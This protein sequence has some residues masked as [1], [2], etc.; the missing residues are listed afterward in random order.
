M[1]TIISTFRLNEKPL[2]LFPK[3]LARGWFLTLMAFSFLIPIHLCQAQIYVDPCAPVEGDGSQANPFKTLVSAVDKAKTTPGSDN[4]VMK[5]GEYLETLTID[6]AVTLTA[7]GGS[8]FVGRAG[9]L[10]WRNMSINVGNGL[11]TNARAYYPSN[12]NGENAAISCGTTFPVIVY[13]HGK[14][15][16]G[17]SVL[18]SW[19]DNELRTDNTR[20]YLQ[21]EGMIKRLAS[22]GA[23]VVSFDWHTLTIHEN[24]IG[25]YALDVLNHMGNE[26]GS[27][28]DLNNVGLIG[29]S[30][31]GAAVMYTAQS[32]YRNGNPSKGIALIAPAFPLHPNLLGMG[33]ET[34]LIN[35]YGP[36]L[37]VHGTNE[38]C[39]QVGTS[40]LK[41]YCQ[42]TTPKHLVVITGANHFGY[43]EGICLDPD[44]AREGQCFYF[45]PWEFL[46]D[47]DGFD[48]PSEV[49]GLIGQKAQSLQQYS[50]GN[51]LEVFFS[52]YLHSNTNS[53]EYLNQRQKN[54]CGSSDQG[55][56]C[57]TFKSDV[58]M[59]WPN[60]SSRNLCSQTE[61]F[62][63]D[64][65]GNS[66]IVINQQT[67]G[68]QWNYLGQF[69]FKIGAYVEI[70]SFGS[71]SV[72]ADAVKFVLPDTAEEFIIDNNSQYGALIKQG[73]WNVSLGGSGWYSEDYLMSTDSNAKFRF[74]IT[75][76][77]IFDSAGC[78]PI[79]YFDDLQSLGVE[80]NVCSCL[81]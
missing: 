7:Q 14:R 60:S 19:C 76:P 47:A 35:L 50:L 68:D 59:W 57:S 65:F 79:K 4:I 69:E 2:L 49:G 52:Y 67:N 38:H 61:I 58:Y 17:Q 66:Q 10:G 70:Q 45:N 23:I 37:V 64:G 11:T 48:N 41:I 8:A 1:I 71:C 21:A 12:G 31:G 9:G 54:N 25:S 46:T 33:D 20:D 51:Y 42:T 16:P 77:T 28:I 39:C 30:T 73:T 44:Q 36:V 22:N 34:D 6:E 75:F 32:L 24:E 40:P 26:F 15:N 13:V 56:P 43:T 74:S 81:E 80:V 18:C 78:E 3:T 53:L 63:G 62:I 27:N 5:S 55:E 29:H 72:I